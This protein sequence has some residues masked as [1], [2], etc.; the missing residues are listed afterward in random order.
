MSYMSYISYRGYVS[1]MGYNRPLVGRV[2]S[3]VVPFMHVSRFTFH[4]SRFI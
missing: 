4:V 3:P 1:Y 2:S